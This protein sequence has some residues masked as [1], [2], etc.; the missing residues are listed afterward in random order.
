M[1]S[2]RPVVIRADAGPL[3][4]VGHV[5]RCV[6][7]AEE[8]AVR[9]YP[10]TFVA[11]LA[12][13]PWAR[14]QVASRGFEIVAPPESVDDEVAA[15]LAF[16]PEWVVLDTYVLPGTVHA[17]LL[18]AGVDVLAFVDGDPTDRTGIV[19]VDQNIGAEA[20]AWPVPDGVVRLA[21]L[22]YALMRDEIVERR[23]EAPKVEANPV[24]QVFAFFGGT[25]AFGAG[26]VLTRA[27][28]GTGAPFDLRVVAAGAWDTA[29]EPGPGQTVTLLDPTDRLA[30]EVLAA[31]L[32]VSAAGTSSWE[33][34]CLGAACAFVCV[35]EN[36]QLSYGRTV[37][38]GLGLGLGLLAE[39]KAAP[40]SAAA[41]LAPALGDH[42]VRSSLRAAAWS[43][44]D[45][46]GRA[47][48]VDAFL[49]AR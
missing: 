45:G 1:N 13:V 18:D 20:D 48:V 2:T 7:L 41:V 25:D 36:Q 29:P 28:I 35:A 42:R 34:L 49:D 44:V 38:S 33:L 21:G 5:M 15:L 22:D 23:P 26:P 43:R 24:P 3:L 46:R 12:E 8:I 40:G 16:D 32:V 19:L 10:V 4:G 37:D 39:V 31:D 27:L 11:D 6:A 30:D 47:R 14:Q 17:G 9:G